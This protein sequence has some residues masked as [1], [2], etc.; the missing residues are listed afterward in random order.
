MKNLSNSNIS[1]KLQNEKEN[2]I[3]IAIQREGHF[4]QKILF[5]EKFCRQAIQTS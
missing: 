1:M 4:N 2:F 3:S 5:A